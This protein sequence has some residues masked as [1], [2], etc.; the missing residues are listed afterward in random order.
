MFED[1]DH[2]LVEGC[3]T[4]EKS[5]SLCQSSTTLADYLNVSSQTC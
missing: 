5:R 4:V 1:E 2:A 3:N